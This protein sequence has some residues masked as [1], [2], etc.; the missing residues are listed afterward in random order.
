M[1]SFIW[2]LPP[3]PTLRLID[4]TAYFFSLRSFNLHFEG[5]RQKVGGRALSYFRIIRIGC[6][7]SAGESASP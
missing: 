7:I 4:L 5:E 1:M 3:S 2:G 6:A